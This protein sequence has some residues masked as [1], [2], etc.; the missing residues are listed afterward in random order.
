VLHRAGVLSDEV[1]CLSD[2]RLNRMSAMLR[3]LIQ[4]SAVRQRAAEKDC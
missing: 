1:A 2:N 4:R 3:A